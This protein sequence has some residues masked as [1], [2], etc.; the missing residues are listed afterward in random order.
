MISS[1][2][3]LLT[4]VC[5]RHL[6]ESSFHLSA[7]ILETLAQDCHWSRQSIHQT[8]SL[9]YAFHLVCCWP[10][11]EWHSKSDH[12]ALSQ[13]YSSIRGVEE[14]RYGFCR[15][16]VPSVRHQG[17]PTAQCPRAMRRVVIWW[18]SCRAR[19]QVQYR[20]CK[21]DCQQ[22]WSAQG[23][24]APARFRLRQRLQQGDQQATKSMSPRM[25]ALSL[26]SKSHNTTASTRKH[27]RSI[28]AK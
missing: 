1:L 12:V 13:V 26:S 4:V 8:P 24:C 11:M 6:P 19:L 27:E 2:R 9:A 18:E 28:Q 23:V 21:G 7:R 14:I 5:L 22:M 10:R 17:R 25:Q 3:W 16:P 20:T 15:Q